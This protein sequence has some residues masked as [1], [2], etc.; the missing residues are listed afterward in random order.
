[1]SLDHLALL[2]RFQGDFLAAVPDADAD[3]RV[4]ACGDWTVRELVEHLAEVHH[5]A[6]GNVRGAKGAPL[7]DGPFEL[8]P[9][10]AAQAAALRRA[11]AETDPDSVGRVL[12]HPEPLGQGPVRFWHRRQVHETLVHLH[13]LLA[14]T[15]GASLLGLVEAEPGVWADAV[16]EVVT[17]LQPRQVGLGRMEPLRHPLCLVATDVAGTPVWVLGA[18]GERADEVAPDVVVSG[19]AEALALTLWHRLTPAEA[20]LTVAGDRADLETALTQS[21]VP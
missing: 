13:D 18:P 6:A 21:I 2:A 11:L 14:A 7:G 15:A 5:W 8:A 1:M 20:G 10:Y 9:H 4:P 17:V 12:A 19:P 3:A 16:D